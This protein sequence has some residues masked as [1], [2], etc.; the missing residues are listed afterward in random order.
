MWVF[1]QWQVLSVSNFWQWRFF[2]RSQILLTFFVFDSEISLKIAKQSCGFF[3]QAMIYDRSFLSVTILSMC[4]IDSFF[5]VCD[6][7]WKWSK[8]WKQRA[9][10]D[11]LVPILFAV[12]FCWKRKKAARN[13]LA[14]WS[15][16]WTKGRAYDVE[17]FDDRLTR[18]VKASSKLLRA[19][20]NYPSFLPQSILILRKIFS[21]LKR[22][23]RVSF[24]TR[25]MGGVER[26]YEMKGE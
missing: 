4:D 19:A 7:F 22:L 17:Q 13:R 25:R 20:R 14:C 16:L 2:D 9:P 11:S 1:S 24:E 8:L 23:F 5:E 26:G 10:A 6:S 15:P 12:E 21:P 3:F 18:R